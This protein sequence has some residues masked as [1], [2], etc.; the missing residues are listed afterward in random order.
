MVFT[1]LSDPAESTLLTPDLLV[2]DLLVLLDACPD[3]LTLDLL[4]LLDAC[5]DLLALLETCSLFKSTRSSLLESIQTAQIYS[6]CL[7]LGI[8]CNI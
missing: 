3:L 6:T 5:P 4:T 8:Y 1:G 2:L 7:K